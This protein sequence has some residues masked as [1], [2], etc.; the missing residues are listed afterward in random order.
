M[1]LPVSFIK[2]NNVEYEIVD[3]VARTKSN[4][5]HLRN[6]KVLIIGDSLSVDGTTW[7]EPFKDLVESVNGTVN[8]IS[9]GGATT[10]SALALVNAL[11]DAY[12]VAIIWLGV[13]DA[14]TSVNIGDQLTAN[15]FSYNYK[16]II[17]KLL[18]LNRD[19]KIYTYAITYAANSTFYK[20]K[21]TYSYNAAIHAL[22]TQLGCVFKD[23]SHVISSDISNTSSMESDGV[24]FKESFSKSVIYDII[25]NGLLSFTSDNYIEAIR[26]TETALTAGTGIT[27]NSA[28]IVNIAG[29]VALL[30]ATFTV[31]SATA[32]NAIILTLPPVL[33]AGSTGV[34]IKMNNISNGAQYFL[35]LSGDK[36]SSA[37]SLPT[38]VYYLESF[39]VPEGDNLLQ[40][41]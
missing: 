12:D 24:H 15:S 20:N 32:A 17:N 31:N 8:N 41:L 34:S 16:A 1:S 9:V 14:Y 4:A 13:N 33:K 18:T 3:K 29:C 36:I 35:T 7:V 37:P 10:G 38:G 23:I 21:S 22:S 2:Q 27:I 6:K 11:T 26:C 25:S 28:H 39:F 19:T 30:K 5:E 40:Y